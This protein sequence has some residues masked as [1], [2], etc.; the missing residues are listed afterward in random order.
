MYV[1]YSPIT[2]NDALQCLPGLMCSPDGSNRYTCPLGY[3]PYDGGCAEC[4]EGE[5]CLQSGEKSFA[6]TDDYT[7]SPVGDSVCRVTHEG[8]NP[9]QT[10]T[11]INTG[12][13]Y[14]Y[15]DTFSGWVPGPPIACDP[16][17]GESCS[18]ATKF[19]CPPTHTLNG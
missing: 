11:H 1:E 6:C 8:K 5:A 18:P 9:D 2:T 14:F 17:K 19:F 3:Y 10:P 16:A 15:E 4:A 12:V 7:F 13:G